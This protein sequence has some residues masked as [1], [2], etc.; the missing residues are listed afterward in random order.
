MKSLLE[1]RLRQIGEVVRPE[2]SFVEGVL[3]RIE[4]RRSDSVRH[5][6]ALWHRIRKPALALVVSMVMTVVLG[7]IGAYGK[8]LA[9]IATNDPAAPAGGG[10]LVFWPLVSILAS[11]ILITLTSVLG[12]MPWLLWCA[13]RRKRY[14]ILWLAIMAFLACTVVWPFINLPAPRAINETVDAKDAAG[15]VTI[16]AIRMH[17]HP[18]SAK[19]WVAEI[20]VANVADTQ[21]YVG[22]EYYSDGG[23]IGPVYHPGAGGRAF[24]R[25]VPPNWSGTLTFD[26]FIPHQLGYGAYVNI[27][28][29]SSRFVYEDHYSPS[30]P[31]D[32][33]E[34]FVKKFVL[35]PTLQQAREAGSTER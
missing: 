3:C 1:T 11:L 15:E 21:R 32:F 30:F 25:P 9:A 12:I 7:L 18:S 8:A 33:E 4:E 24:G 20:D 34:I 10:F 31:G 13:T 2:P 5:T 6:P 17:P 23:A 16:S 22:L 27:R 19:Y 35:V 14:A 28:L 29:G 26:L